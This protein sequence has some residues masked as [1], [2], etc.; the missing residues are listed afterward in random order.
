P[1]TTRHFRNLSVTGTGR[2]SRTFG[3]EVLA[4]ELELS[5][6][7]THVS[8]HGFDVNVSRGFRAWS[9]RLTRGGPLAVEPARWSG[10]MGVNT[11]SRAPVQVRMGVDLSADEEGGWSRAGN[12]NFTIRMKDIYELQLGARLT[13][14]R[15][16]AQYVTTV[17]D[18]AAAPTF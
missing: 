13:R 10:G 5:L 11:N 14:S 18:P 1:T 3:G 15:T 6:D 8:Q 7:A 9:D 2:S 12:T 4:E 16:P 17:A